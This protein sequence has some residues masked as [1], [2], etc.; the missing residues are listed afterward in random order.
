MQPFQAQIKK[1]A[2]LQT[3]LVVLYTQEAV[4]WGA[5]NSWVQPTPATPAPPLS[6]QVSSMRLSADV[7]THDQMVIYIP[8]Y[9]HAYTLWASQEGR[10]H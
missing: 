10:L 6:L 2:D 9:M 1:D 8:A 4:L 3:V 7:Q 5:Q